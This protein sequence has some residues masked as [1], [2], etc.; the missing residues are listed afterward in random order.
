MNTSLLRWIAPA[1]VA[2]FVSGPA[3][4]AAGLPE[5]A[6]PIT[7]PAPA[8]APAQ[9]TKSN[10]APKAQ[11][12][13]SAVDAS[14]QYAQREQQS[15]GIENFKGGEGVSLYMSSTILAVLLLVVLL[16]VLL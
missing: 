13:R 3:F 1:L 5:T 2:V 7:A 10:Q 9:V 12:T 11:P 14:A 6:V 16:V 4:A 15:K 8:Q